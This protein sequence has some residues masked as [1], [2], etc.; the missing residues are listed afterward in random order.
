MEVVEALEL[1]F[2]LD[3]AEAIAF[4]AL[5]RRESRGAH[6][7]TDF[8]SRDDQKY[9]LH[10]LVYRSAEGPLTRELPVRITRWQPAERRY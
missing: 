5:T 9:L 2:M 4:S 1:D 6:F 8:P 7:R 10:Q 3:V